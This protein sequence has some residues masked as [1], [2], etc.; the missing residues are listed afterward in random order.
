MKK[1]P[2]QKFRVCRFYVESGPPSLFARV[3]Y[4]MDAKTNIKVDRPHFVC[5]VRERR[6]PAQV[7]RLVNNFEA[8]RWEVISAEVR[9]DTG[10]FISS[11]W[12]RIYAKRY[13][14]VTI[15]IGDIAETIYES[16]PP[17]IWS[18]RR[19]MRAPVKGKNPARQIYDFVEKINRNLMES[20]T[21][22]KKN[23][24][25]LAVK[26]KQKN[27][28]SSN[29]FASQ[30]D[31]KVDPFD[32]LENKLPVNVV[33]IDN[34]SK[35]VDRIVENPAKNWPERYS[36]KAKVF[37]AAN[38]TK[39]Y[40]HFAESLVNTASFLTGFVEDPD[41]LFVDGDCLEKSDGWVGIFSSLLAYLAVHRADTLT[42]LD[43]AGLMNWLA[44][45]NDKA[46][47]PESIM[48]IGVSAEF[49]CLSDLCARMQWLLMM[50]G[51][52]LNDVVIRF[53]RSD[54]QICKVQAELRK[55][56]EAEEKAAEKTR[57]KKTG[58]DIG[59]KKATPLHCSSGGHS[60]LGI[61]HVSDPPPKQQTSSA[62]SFSHVRFDRG[63]YIVQ[64]GVVV[65]LNRQDE[66][67]DDDNGNRVVRSDVDAPECWKGFGVARPESDG[68]FGGI[69]TEDWVD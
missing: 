20:D 34:W 2:S 45:A 13:Y 44:K 65:F 15:G 10:K 24:I 8:R 58:G 35:V 64:D 67:T 27:G 43:V 28:S 63:T 22:H 50:T 51:F 21:R 31:W 46:S 68:R 40:R 19:R 38:T 52:N 69:I 1:T 9:A 53:K 39:D 17:S 54:E 18:P 55:R 57:T 14:V 3:K 12:G 33:K 29:M 7:V 5:R 41:L 6:I 61:G 36:A 49:G 16:E 62:D 48:A 37:K 23:N 4:I 66:Y 42:K 30:S 11:T 60:K 47:L 25:V 26:Q 56:R 59:E 32:G